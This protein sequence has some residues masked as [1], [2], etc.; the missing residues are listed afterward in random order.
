[1]NL[2]TQ[3]LN[4]LSREF[5]GLVIGLASD[6]FMMSCRVKFAGEITQLLVVFA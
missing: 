1:V 2:G 4:D 5:V 3:F 6:M